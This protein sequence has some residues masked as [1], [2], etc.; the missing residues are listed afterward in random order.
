VFTG[1]FDGFLIWFKNKGYAFDF[2]VFVDCLAVA[3]VCCGG[4]CLFL[5]P[6]VFAGAAP[7]GG[8]GVL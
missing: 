5:A 3:S 4:G 7:E 6:V 1:R 8:M 2:Q